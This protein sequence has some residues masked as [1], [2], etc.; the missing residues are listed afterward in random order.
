MRKIQFFLV[1]IGF[2]A[3]LFWVVTL[4]LPS[5]ITVLRSVDIHADETR[6]AV[7][8]SNFS[9]WKNWYPAFSDSNVTIAIYRRN[10]TSFASLINKESNKKATLALLKPGTDS[11]QVLLPG[12]NEDYLFAIRPDGN[13]ETQVTWFI[14]L[15]LGKYPWKKFAG[16]FFD[17]A[18]GAKYEAVLNS[19]KKYI[20]SAH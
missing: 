6:V 1:F 15:D 3:L 14:N 5:K 16:M 2:M 17:K 19:L 12:D 20:E 9:N 8:I 7:Q 4:F 13:G 18:N 11:I 10:D